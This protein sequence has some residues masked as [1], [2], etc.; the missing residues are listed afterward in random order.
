M[1]H[2]RPKIAFFFLENSTQNERGA[3]KHILIFFRLPEAV[4]GQNL[5]KYVRSKLKENQ[6]LEDLLFEIDF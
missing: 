5:Q 2:I 3:L 1:L 6:I 4:Y